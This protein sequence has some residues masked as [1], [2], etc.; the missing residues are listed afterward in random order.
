[1]HDALLALLGGLL[2]GAAASIFLFTHGRIAGISGILAGLLFVRD[3]D[4]SC[5]AGF[6]AGLVA[7]GLTLA[8]LDVPAVVAPEASFVTVAIAGVLVGF[9][10]RLA[11]GCTS[12]HAVCGVSRLSPR[13]LVATAVFLGA[14]MTTVATVRLLGGA[15]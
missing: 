3:R 11:N 1:M 9:G 10:S 12:G 7:V 15:A 4:T 5:R 13:S 6:L 8:L 14:G 2:L